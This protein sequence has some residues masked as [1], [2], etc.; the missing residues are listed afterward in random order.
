[1]NI[2]LAE[3]LN[4]HFTDL[5]H[6]KWLKLTKDEI[7]LIQQRDY[8]ENNGSDPFG[9][10]ILSILRELIEIENSQLEIQNRYN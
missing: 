2:S 9:E 8:L 10:E 3:K 4:N 5:D 1:M 6:K 7:D